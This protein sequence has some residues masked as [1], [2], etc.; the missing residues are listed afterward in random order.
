MQEG[1]VMQMHRQMR[2]YIAVVETN[3]FFEAGEICHI[4]Q[5]AVSQQIKALEEELQVQ[6]LERHGRKFTVTPAGRYFYEQ[7][8]KQVQAPEYEMA[9]D[10]ATGLYKIV[11][12]DENNAI[13]DDF[14]YTN[15][16][17]LTFSK[18]GKQN[19]NTT[20]SCR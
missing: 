12:T 17:G 20:R 5:S 15:G 10:T 13:N 3:S 9:Y 7:A 16:N 4:S 6:L 1:R 19:W 11:L 8:R 18:S 14:P 2:Y